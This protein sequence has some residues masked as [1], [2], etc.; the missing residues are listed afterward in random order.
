MTLYFIT[1]CF[2]LFCFV[3]LLGTTIDWHKLDEYK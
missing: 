2:A 1:L 3:M